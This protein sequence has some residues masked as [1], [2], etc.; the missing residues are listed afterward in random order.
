MEPKN[1]IK[2]YNLV[3]SEESSE[4]INKLQKNIPNNLKLLNDKYLSS[5][6]F[7][8]KNTGKILNLDYIPKE[9]FASLKNQNSQN[10]IKEINN[11]EKNQYNSS[12]LD[13][14]ATN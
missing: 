14:K 1:N 7:Y 4:E 9:L 2:N 12:Y 11:F 8:N 3:K 5:K 13:E 6:D 10:N